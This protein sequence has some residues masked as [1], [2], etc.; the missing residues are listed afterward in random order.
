MVKSPHNESNRQL[1]EL[2]SWNYKLN[3]SDWPKLFPACGEKNQSPIDLMTDGNPDFDYED[4]DFNKIYTN[5]VD[6]ITVN[7]N[8]HTSQVS[9]DK[10]G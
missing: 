3:G 6:E 8:G 2:H 4:D 7:W 9:I 1:E 5:Q 10:P